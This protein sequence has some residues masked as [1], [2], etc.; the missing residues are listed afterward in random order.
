M[1]PYHAAEF[2]LWYP[3]SGDSGPFSEDLTNMAQFTGSARFV[4]TY[5]EQTQ[6]LD[7]VV[8]DDKSA[9]SLF[10]HIPG[11][12]KEDRQSKLDMMGVTYQEYTF[13]LSFS[14]IESKLGP[15]FIKKAQESAQ[16]R[17]DAINLEIADAKPLEGQTEESRLNSFIEIKP[18]KT[19]V[20]KPEIQLIYIK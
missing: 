17:S 7:I 18:D 19:A 2:P 20:A 8:V 3:L 12:G 1:P 6:Q 9:H 13:S 15:E 4:F 5:N 10:L 14:E 11:A 16:K